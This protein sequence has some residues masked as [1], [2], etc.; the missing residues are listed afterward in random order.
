MSPLQA[1]GQEFWMIPFKPR[2]H[3]SA[4]MYLACVRFAGQMKADVSRCHPDTL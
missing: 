3:L 2:L 1:V 4:A